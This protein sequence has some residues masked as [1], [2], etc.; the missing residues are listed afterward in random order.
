MATIYLRDIP[1]DLH[2]SAKVLAAQEGITLKEL[3]SR[4]LAEATNNKEGKMNIETFYNPDEHSTKGIWNKDQD[5]YEPFTSEERYTLLLPNAPRPVP[6]HERDFRID[7]LDDT[8]GDLRIYV[9][10]QT[11]DDYL[12]TPAEGWV[13]AFIELENGDPVTGKEAIGGNLMMWEDE[14]GLHPWPEPESEAR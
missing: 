14:K 6:G 11:G 13:E 5:A 12:Y 9:Q 4:L 7:M 3:I 10:R 2:R 8:P 1:E